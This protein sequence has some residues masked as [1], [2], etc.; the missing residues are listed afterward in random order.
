MTNRAIRGRFRLAAM[1]VMLA[2]GIACTNPRSSAAL[3]GQAPSAAE[4]RA[5][6]APKR[7]TLAISGNAPSLNNKLNLNNSIQGVDHLEQLVSAGV[8]SVDRVGARHP[9]L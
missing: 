8:T 5:P 4:T 2:T 9:Q 1:V 6:A 7:V 3:S